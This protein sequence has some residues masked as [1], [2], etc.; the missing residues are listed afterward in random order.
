MLV[1]QLYFD[2]NM[3]KNNEIYLIKIEMV[4]I[5]NLRT[6]ADSVVILNNPLEHIQLI[7]PPHP[8]DIV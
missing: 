6:N 2:Y 4:Y 1:F 7:Q 8:L 3:G 5:Y